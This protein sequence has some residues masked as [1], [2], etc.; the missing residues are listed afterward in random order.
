MKVYLEWDFT[1]EELAA[2][3]NHLGEKTA[4]AGNVRD[5]MANAVRDAT[6]YAVVELRAAKDDPFK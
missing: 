4:D 1:E 6:E 5:F 2:V 3:A